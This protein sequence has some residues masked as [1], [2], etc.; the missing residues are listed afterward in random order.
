[1]SRKVSVY[2]YKSRWPLPG[3][4][5]TWG[6]R[7]A[8]ASLDGCIP[9]GPSARE[10]CASEVDADGFLRWESDLEAIDSRP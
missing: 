4:L 2:R 9:I 5:P 3:F 1:M 6:T 7:E 8:I 10:V